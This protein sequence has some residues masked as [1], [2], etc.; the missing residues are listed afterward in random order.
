M[1]VDGRSP[2][3]GGNQTGTVPAHAHSRARALVGA[4]AVTAV[5][6]EAEEKVGRDFNMTATTSTLSDRHEFDRIWK[7]WRS[8]ESIFVET[9]ERPEGASSSRRRMCLSVM[10]GHRAGPRAKMNS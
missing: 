2:F 1:E 3:F 8:F 5:A 9:R 4:A 7:I 10:G 6:I